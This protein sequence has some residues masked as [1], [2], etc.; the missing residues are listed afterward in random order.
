MKFEEK[1]G[2][3]STKISNQRHLRSIR[4]AF[5]LTLPLTLIGSISLLIAQPPITS[6][7]NAFLMAIKDFATSN[8]GLIIPY[9]LTTGIY[10]LWIVLAVAYSHAKEMKVNEMSAVLM[11]G[12]SFL[13]VASIPDKNLMPMANIGAKGIFGAMIIGL[14]SVELFAWFIRHNIKIKMP[15]SVPQGVSAPFEAVLAFGAVMLLVIGVNSA[16]IAMTGMDFITATMAVFQPLIM[17]SDTLIALVVCVVLQRALWFFGIHGGSVTGAILN[18]ILMANL[19][20]NQEAFAAGKDMPFIFTN[21]VFSG[22]LWGLS[23][24]P[25]ALVMI[26]WCKSSRLKT[27]GKLGVVPAFCGIGEPIN[28]GTPFVL[29]TTLLIPGILQFVVNCGAAYLCIQFGLINRVVVSPPLGIP[30]IIGVVLASMDYRAIVLWIILLVVDVLMY[31]P[32]FKIYDRQCMQEEEAYEAE[33]TKE[34]AAK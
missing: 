10:G 18:P 28:F 29:N 17:S 12:V 14:V 1:L 32:F 5:M 4:D 20:A 16:I 11:A 2:S 24:L 8:P 26:F 31:L 15:P 30:T 6:T 7:T 33:N 3:I 21:P 13:C 25:A 34:L 22:S 9:N 23:F 19:V 27:V